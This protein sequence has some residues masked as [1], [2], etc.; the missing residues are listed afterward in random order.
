MFSEEKERSEIS[1]RL[2]KLIRK[3]K[4]ETK[5]RFFVINVKSKFKN[6]INRLGSL[7]EETRIR[8][9]ERLDQTSPYFNGLANNYDSQNKWFKERIDQLGLDLIGDLKGSF[10]ELNRAKLNYNINL[11]LNDKGN[12]VS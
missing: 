9:V 6:L 11:T 12:E 7:N 1:S 10:E 5:V 3:V 2:E 4:V 8:L